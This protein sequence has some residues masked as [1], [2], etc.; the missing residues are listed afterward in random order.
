MLTASTLEERALTAT[1]YHHGNLREALIDAGLEILREEGLEGLS[2]RAC[3]A[4]AGVSHGAP[5]N[6]F[7]SLAAL[8]AA[9]A[10]EGFRRFAA[11]MRAGMAETTG[12]EAETAPGPGT[13]DATTSAK[14][15]V[16]GCARGYVS[17]VE[18]NPD[19]FRLMFSM[20]R[21]PRIDPDLLPASQDAYAVLREISAGLLPQNCENPIDRTSVETLLWSFLHGYATLKVNRQFFTANAETGTDPALEDVFPRL[22]YGLP[23]ET[24]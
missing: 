13:G 11:R 18:D 5:K 2:L 4:R 19:L 10:A 6:H 9:I 15:K 14:A 22:L 17:F 24:P 1:R 7:A 16:L 3:A 12:P 20:E 8:Q 23:E 21:D